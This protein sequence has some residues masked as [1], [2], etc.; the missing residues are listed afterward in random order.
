MKTFTINGL[1]ELLEKDRGVV[2]R[3]LRGT[4]PDAT[5]RGRP[6]YRMAMVRGHC[7]LLRLRI[8]NGLC[9]WSDGDGCHDQV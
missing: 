4:V 8:W 7:S 9:D 2:V 1:S 3:S 5:E 6:R